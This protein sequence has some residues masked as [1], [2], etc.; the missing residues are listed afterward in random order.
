MD[1]H[2]WFNFGNQIVCDGTTIDF[3]GYV[4]I[5]FK[6]LPDGTWMDHYNAYGEGVDQDGNL[7]KWHD[8][9]NT[10]WDGTP[11]ITHEV[12][13]LTLQGPKGAKLNLRIVFVMNGNGEIVRDEFDGLCN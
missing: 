12:R 2:Q 8:A 6:T 10:K 13:N 4:Q 1:L 9:W 3:S 11:A 7:W 5:I